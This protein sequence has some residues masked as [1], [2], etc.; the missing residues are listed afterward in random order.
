MALLAGVEAGL[1]PPE[2]RERL[3]R[4]QGPGELR[5][6]ILAFMVDPDSDREVRAWRGETES[7]ARAAQV[8]ADVGQLPAMARLPWFSELVRRAAF[9]SIEDRRSMVEAARRV[10]TAA[11][12]VKPLDRLRWLALRHGLGH[13]QKR[14]VVTPVVPSTAG[15][16]AFFASNRRPI[17]TYSAFLARL[18]PLYSSDVGIDPLG[19]RW[20]DAV[21]QRFFG[22]QDI[23]PAHVPDSD[24]LVHA[25]W[26]LQTMPWMSRPP[27][28]RAWVGEAV[29]HSGPAGL[30][31]EA[32]DALYLTCMMLDS[33]MPPDLAKAFISS[34][35]PATTGASGGRG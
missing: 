34:I 6:A 23:K 5:A 33:P 12:V 9:G 26:A 29:S 32:A 20:Y 1:V 30:A 19:A 15:E 28:I 13:A 31:R 7:F 17:G 21:M 25:L 27:L 16:L 24:A 11:G 10:M 22:V 8:Y 2:L 14:A 3:A 4:L 18:V 35:T